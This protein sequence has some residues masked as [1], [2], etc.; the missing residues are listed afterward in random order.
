MFGSIGGVFSAFDLESLRFELA[1]C[2]EESDLGRRFR[3]DEAERLPR[4]RDSAMELS[5]LLF[6]GLMVA[7][8]ERERERERALYREREFE[9]EKMEEE[10]ERLRDRCL[11]LS[12]QCCF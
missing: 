5:E 3:I 4:K 1:L 11:G 7:M 6:L 9:F 10:S 12:V 2:F 8:R